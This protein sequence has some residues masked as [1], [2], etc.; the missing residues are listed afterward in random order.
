M[1][2]TNMKIGSLLKLCASLLVVA[3]LSGCAA[4]IIGGAAGAGTYAYVKGELKATENAS[5]DRVWNAS[6]SA[7]SELEFTVTTRQK[8][9]LQG[10]LVARTASDK[11][12][13]IDL[14]K[15]SENQTEI[16]VRVG[17]FGD[18]DL[19]KLI[20]QKIERGL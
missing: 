16:R 9:A 7:L 18:E 19:S 20:I 14:K 13:E 8:D 10:R 17:T 11:R 3:L 5:L 1:L 15:L 6:L 4:V 2:I 12:V